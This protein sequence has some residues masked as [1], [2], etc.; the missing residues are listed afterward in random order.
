MHEL[1]RHRFIFAPAVRPA[2]LRH[3][4]TN[5]AGV[6][7][8][9]REVADIGSAAVAHDVSPANFWDNVRPQTKLLKN[10]GDA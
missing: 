9:I 3:R 7:A 6:R 5:I 4:A 8:W 10:L 1:L 2:L